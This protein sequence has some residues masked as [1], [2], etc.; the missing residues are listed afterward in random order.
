VDVLVVDVG[1][2]GVKIAVSNSSETRRFKS[3]R[4]L[5]PHTLVAHVKTETADW[6]YD[7][8]A[9]G[10]P[11]L[12]EQN[13]AGAEPGNLGRGWVGFDFAHAFDRPVRIANDAVMQALGAYDS[14]RMLF[15]G[16]G[17]GIGSALITEHVLVPLEL[18]C[19]RHSSGAKLSDLLGRAGLNRIGLPAWQRVLGQTAPMLKEAFVVDYIVLGG[20]NAKRVNPLPADTRRGGNRDAIVG[21]FR[22]WEEVVEP[23][24]QLP[25]SAWRIVR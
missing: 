2:S 24:D 22:L 6:Q 17:T 4:S 18:G 11:G 19:L 8:I 10:Y 3:G 25:R 16:L 15:L 20:G 1:G 7:A 9:I 23:H 13:Q 14:G 5:T 21:G 12:V